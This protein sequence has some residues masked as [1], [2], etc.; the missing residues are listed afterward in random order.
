MAPSHVPA[1]ALTSITCD[2]TG[3]SHT[4]C[5]GGK[6]SPI[7]RASKWR[8]GHGPDSGLA[9]SRPQG[10]RKGIGGVLWE[11]I[12]LSSTPGTLGCWP[13]SW[14]RQGSLSTR[15]SQGQQRQGWEAP[16]GCPVP[17]CGGFIR[18]L[19][20]LTITLPIYS[21]ASRAGPATLEVIRQ[22]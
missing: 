6:R 13:S 11:E 5:G 1:S 3:S 2:L 18:A 7:F 12:P 4:L 22:P 8:C 20:A 19:Q 16:L 14:G 17:C 21:P 9:W 10:A 15:G